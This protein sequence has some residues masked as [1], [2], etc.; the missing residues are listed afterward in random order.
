M[1]F[2]IIPML[3]VAG[4]TMTS[5]AQ[6][7]QTPK[8][9]PTYSEEKEGSKKRTHVGKEPAAGRTGAASELRRVEQSNAKVAARKTD[10]GKAARNKPVLKAQKNDE[11]PPI[12]FASSGG[13]GK[14]K[15]K[16]KNEL[17]RRLRHKGRS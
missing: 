11:N 2:S 15:G 1:K 9:K 13:P 6:K 7:L 3:V 16:S 8:G 17:N 12:H 10:G 4:L 14:G 5:S